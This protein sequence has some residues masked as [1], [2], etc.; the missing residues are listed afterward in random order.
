M[1]VDLGGRAIVVTGAASGIGCAIAEAAAGARLLLVDRDAEGCAAVAETLRDRAEVAV[2]VA[3]LADPDAPASIAADAKARFGGIDGLVNAAGLTTR[4]TVA[5]G[6]IA[7]W[8]SLFAVNARAPFFLMQGAI[9]S[10]LAR[11]TGG[12]IVNILSINAHCGGSDLAIY[13]ATKGAL[14]TLTKNAAQAHM[15]DR[16]RVN[17]INLG[18]TLTEAEH[19]MQ[20]RTLGHGEDWV[21]RIASKKP[22]GRLLAPQ[23]AANLAIFLLSDASAPLTGAAID[24]EQKVTEAP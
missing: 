2:Y 24:L 17:G 18:W 1:N 22:W 10:M 23:E 13:S 20:A 11:R 15:A 16:I 14:M 21:E 6:A 19:R 5:D 8:E 3:D 7:E 4:A 9:R 12:A